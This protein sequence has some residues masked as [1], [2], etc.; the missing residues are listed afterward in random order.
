MLLNILALVC[1]LVAAV[2]AYIG[3]HDGRR[4][5]WGVLVAAGLA[6]WKL[7]DLGILH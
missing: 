3:P 4:T 2:L 5:Y 6:L 1:F 7:N